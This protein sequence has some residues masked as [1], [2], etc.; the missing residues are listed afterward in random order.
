M[1]TAIATTKAPQAIGPYSQAVIVDGFVFASGQIALDPQTGNLVGESVAAQTEQ[2][3]SNIQALLSAAGSDLDHVVKTTC[4]LT[5]IDEFSA[6][7][8]VY[9]RYFTTH[10]P[11]RS[12]VGVAGLPKGACV[13]VE[14]IAQVIA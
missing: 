4:F 2:I 12:A 11:A 13:E 1:I 3:F 10:L 6:F 9:G 8:E 7:N 14:V 5:S